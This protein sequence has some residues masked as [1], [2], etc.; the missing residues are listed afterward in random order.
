VLI[1]VVETLNWSIFTAPDEKIHKSAL[2][3]PVQ[4]LAPAIL[5][6]FM[7]RTQDIHLPELSKPKENNPKP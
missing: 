1:L 3:K 7:T 5:P 2:Y 6:A 4:F